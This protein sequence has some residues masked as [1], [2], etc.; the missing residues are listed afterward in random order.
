MRSFPDKL[1]VYEI[2]TWVWLSELGE[3]YGHKIT[4][5]NVPDEALDAIAMP[6]LDV[7][8]LMGVWQRSPF[9][10]ENALKYRHEYQGA[11]PDLS[12]DVVIGSA[13]AIGRYEVDERIGGR[14]G[15]ATFRKK[16]KDRGLRLMLDYVPNHVA[17]DHPWVK[18]HP[19]F[20]VMGKPE[21]V[22]KRPSDFYAITDNDGNQVVLAHGRDP[23]FPGWSD[24]A[25]LNAFNPELRKAVVELLRDIATQCD[26]V[27]CDMAMLLFSDIFAGT[28]K[29]KRCTTVFWKTT[30]RSCGSIWSLPWTTRSR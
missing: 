13:Y 27:R 17:C 1:F 14:D 22:K 3:K 21:D 18:E 9:G 7:I 15:L 5:E 23:L 16:L 30:C 24:T 10:R 2:N 25:Q 29:T 8:W 26:G 20:I 11:L 19:D 12:D 4:L 6:G 28:W